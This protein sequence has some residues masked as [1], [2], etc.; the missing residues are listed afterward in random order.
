MPRRAGRR[1]AAFTQAQERG[2]RKRLDQQGCEGGAEGGAEGGPHSWG[3][4]EGTV[5]GGHPSVPGVGCRGQGAVHAGDER[6]AGQ[7][8]GGL[9]AG[10]GRGDIQGLKAAQGQTRRLLTTWTSS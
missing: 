1:P 9:D 10:G 4:A 6:T 7:T 8:A 2:F 3:G 5:P